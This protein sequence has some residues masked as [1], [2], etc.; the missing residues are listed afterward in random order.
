[1]KV[2]KNKIK[3]GSL[4]GKMQQCKTTHLKYFIIVHNAVRYF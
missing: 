4:L 2:L 3:H 1:M